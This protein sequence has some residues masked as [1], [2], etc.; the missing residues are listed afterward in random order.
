MASQALIEQPDF[1][2]LSAWA[3]ACAT[4]QGNNELSTT[5]FLFAAWYLNGAQ[6]IQ[7]PADIS[8]QLAPWGKLAPVITAPREEKM[9]LSQELR[10]SLVTGSEMSVEDWLRLLLQQAPQASPPE[11]PTDHGEEWAT[12][13]PWIRSAMRAHAV[14]E[15]TLA[16]LALGIVSAVQANALG[17]HVDFAHLCQAH[18][19]ELLSWLEHAAQYRRGLEPDLNV[20][21]S[22]AVA[23]SEDLR[24]AIKSVDSDEH[25][26]SATWRWLQAAVNAASR[27][28]RALQVAYHEAGHAVALH[29]LSPEASLKTVTIV[30]KDDSSGHVH[31]ELNN[32][33]ESTY[34]FSLEHM[35]EDLVVKL[36]GRM[37]ENKRFGEGRGDTGA[38]SDFS[39]A[40]R[41]TWL[42]VT[43]FGLDPV[44]GPVNLAAIQN[45]SSNSEHIVAANA[46]GWL[47]DLA[48]RRTHVW[49]RWGMQETKRLI[50][51]HWTQVEAL[52]EAVMRQKTLSDRDARII[53]GALPL[54]GEFALQPLPLE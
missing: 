15:A 47:Q 42:A 1:V 32:G 11:N 45:L 18:A 31:R 6:K 48:Q 2:L 9:P 44:F 24:E 14:E 34:R 10:A 7:L 23:Q 53:L 25:A 37:A 54:K 43:A 30:E 36:A 41:S 3:K 17:K 46:S 4:A 16:S 29:V 40:T 13:A 39:A 28:N 49:L 51:T 5:H 26:P 50:E 20:E 8:A 38:L 22:L 35:Q 19:D 33:Y 21:P 12:L 27:Y 52:A